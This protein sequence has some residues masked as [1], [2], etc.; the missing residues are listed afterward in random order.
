MLNVN[1]DVKEKNGDEKQRDN[2][3]ND[4]NAKDESDDDDR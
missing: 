2:G 3:D 4:C 1:I